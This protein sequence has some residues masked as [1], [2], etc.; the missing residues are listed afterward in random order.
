MDRILTV[1]NVL[2]FLRLAT[3]PLFVY[4]FVTQRRDAAVILYGVAAATDFFDG[5]IA[6]RTDSVTELG[7][8]LDPLA[9]RI[10]IAA[11]AVAL[12]VTGVLSPWLA[13][14]VVGRDV[15]V[16]AAYP[17]VQRASVARI[18]VNLVGKTATAALL[19][20]LTCLAIA[21]TSAPW[22]GLVQWPGYVAVV[23]GAV[24][25]WVA[26]GIYARQAFRLHHEDAE[27]RC[28]GG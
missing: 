3:V 26:G 14:A 24:L 9:D 21:E 1:P 16:L 4:L 2:S 12:V 20:G 27:S 22:S 6:R 25:Y 19:F 11:L 8:L 7:T 28:S 13:A 15:V 23:A 5:Y 18:R 10:F 17:F